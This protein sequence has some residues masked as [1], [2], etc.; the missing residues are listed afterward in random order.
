MLRIL[1]SCVAILCCL[2]LANLP[3]QSQEKKEEKKAVKKAPMPSQPAT[4]AKVPYGKHERQVLDFYQA[5]SD[6]PPP[7]VLYIH[8]GRR[9]HGDK[10]SV[11]KVN[12]YLNAGSA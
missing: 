7:V 8:G 2:S 6:K 3:A 12:P 4:F 1:W 5:K 10:N 9:Q 11:G